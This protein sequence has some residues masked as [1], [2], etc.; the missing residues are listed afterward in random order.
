MRRWRV[1]RENIGV[2]G[3]CLLTTTALCFAGVI[4]VIGLAMRDM[5]K[6]IVAMVL[7]GIG[8]YGMRILARRAWQ[9]YQTYKTVAIEVVEV[10]ELLDSWREPKRSVYWH[11]QLIVIELV[12]K[13]SLPNEVRLRLREE[14][15]ELNVASDRDDSVIFM[16]TYAFHR[17]L[18]TVC[19]DIDITYCRVTDRELKRIRM[20]VADALPDDEQDEWGASDRLGRDIVCDRLNDWYSVVSLQEVRELRELLST[21]VV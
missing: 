4:G 14:V 15:R 10:I 19:Q 17:Q 2:A 5:T 8:A 18:R 21:L 12:A 6:S 16:R 1:W 13:P 20:T 7:C 9:Y 3:W 11:N